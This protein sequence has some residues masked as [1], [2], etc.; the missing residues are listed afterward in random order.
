MRVA[1]VRRCARPGLF[2]TPSRSEDLLRAAAIKQR[3]QKTPVVD[4][5]FVRL[6]SFVGLARPC[7]RFFDDGT[8]TS[9]HD[10]PQQVHAQ[11]EILQEKSED[12]PI[13]KPS[14]P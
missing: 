7:H 6:N 3:A 4:W 13:T 10:Y 14:S 2:R 8:K 12:W 1:T 11:P 9:R 5:A